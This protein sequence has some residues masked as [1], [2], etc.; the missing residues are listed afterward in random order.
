[1]LGLGLGIPKIGNKV[2]AVIK[3]LKSFWNKNTHQWNHENT[4]WEKI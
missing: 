4:H 3:H 2:I 1:M